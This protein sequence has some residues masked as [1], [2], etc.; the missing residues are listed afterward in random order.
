MVR[1][2][3]FVARYGGDEFVIILPETTAEQAA[4]IAERIR[5]GIEQYGFGTGD[6]Q[7]F[8]LT[9]SFGVAA[10][11][12]HGL[13]SKELIQRA[14]AAMYMAKDASKNAVALAF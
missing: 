8:K 10:Y 13:T 11:P 12:E 4:H 14:D 7:Q 6:V 5:Q 3:D 1:D 2:T 9:A